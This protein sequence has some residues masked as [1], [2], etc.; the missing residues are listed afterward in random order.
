MFIDFFYGLKG[1]GLKVTLGEWL[2]LQ[3]ALSMDLAGSSL[4][5]FYYLARMIL[6][7][8]DM[9]QFIT[10]VNFLTRRLK[11]FTKI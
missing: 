9:E 5:G 8:T 10:I 6:A 2:T 11:E 3:Q 1:A 4:T 7:E